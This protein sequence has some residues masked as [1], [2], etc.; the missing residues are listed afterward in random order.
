M[1]I[2]DAIE[3]FG[4]SIAAGVAVAILCGVLSV[5][6]V[7]KRLAFVGQGVSHAA[8]GGVGLAFALGLTGL[9]GAE[10]SRGAAVAGSVGMYAIVLAF[11]AASAL[12]IAAMSDKVSTRPDTAIGIVLV[13]SMAVGFLLHG[14][15]GRRAYEANR[16][17]PP[18]VEEVLFGS[19][20]TVD[21]IDAWIAGGAAVLILVTL[22]WCRRPM[23]FWAF[24]EPAAAAFGVRTR[25]MERL[26]LVLIAAAIV[27]TMRVA[28]IVLTTAALVLPGATALRLSD[29]LGPVLVLAVLA[30]L[31]GVLGGLWA[32][33]ELNSLGGPCIVLVLTAEYAIARAAGWML[34]RGSATGSDA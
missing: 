25:W 28:G 4:P 10:A 32:T 27:V 15:A 21:V 13:A 8:F 7:L 1:P 3:L 18:G 16:P 24:D 29:R 26:L 22:W 12:V 17:Q 31:V 5:P 20:L 2:R 19:V 34:S 23:L 14:Y 11:C 9:A 33:F 30:S 6:V